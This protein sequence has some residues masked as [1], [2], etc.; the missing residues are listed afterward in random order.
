MV[1]CYNCLQQGHIASRCPSRVA[2]YTALERAKQDVD[3]LREE[4]EATPPILIN[5]EVNETKVRDILVDNRTS[6]TIV[7]KSLVSEEKLMGED[8]Y[9]YPMRPWSHSQVPPGKGIGWIGREVIPHSGSS[10]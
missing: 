8:L 1:I 9:L 5:S 4:L 2:L 6:T 7:S 3:H 10:L